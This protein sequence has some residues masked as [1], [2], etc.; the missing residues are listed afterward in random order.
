MIGAAIVPHNA[1]ADSLMNEITCF[2]EEDADPE[3]IDSTREI[4]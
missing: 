2:I 1:M 4:R 3:L